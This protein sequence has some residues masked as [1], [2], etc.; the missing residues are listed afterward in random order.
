MDSDKDALPS[1]QLTFEL[2]PL[3]ETNYFLPARN[4]DLSF[5]GVHTALLL[6]QFAKTGRKSKATSSF[7]TVTPE[8]GFKIVKIEAETGQFEGDQKKR[9]AK[10][11]PGASA[12]DTLIALMDMAINSEQEK[13]EFDQ[14][15]ESSQ[16]K[17]LT[18]TSGKSE[19]PIQ[20]TIYFKVKDLAHRIGTQEKNSK[21]VA[22]LQHLSRTRFKIEGTVFHNGSEQKVSHE[23]YYV[24]SITTARRKTSNGNDEAVFSVTLDEKIVKN[25]FENQIAR[26][27]RTKY[28][29][30]PSGPLRKLYILLNSRAHALKNKLVFLTAEEIL[31]VTQIS[32]ATFANKKEQYFKALI[33]AGVVEHYEGIRRNGISIF[34]FKLQDEIEEERN[35]ALHET[36]KYLGIL[37]KL[38]EFDKGF[39]T[40]KEKPSLL[41][42]GEKEIVNL[43]EEYPEV[44]LF[45]RHKYPRVILW[46]DML[47]QS[48]IKYQNI[49]SI[50][51]LLISC[52]KKGQAPTL[53]TGYIPA[54]K[55][56]FSA[57]AERQ[58]LAEKAKREIEAKRLKE[59]LEKNAN[60]AYEALTS[61][62]KKRLSTGLMGQVSS[63]FSFGEQVVRGVCIGALM[64]AMEKGHSPSDIKKVLESYELEKG[65]NPLL[66]QEPER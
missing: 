51:G 52:L 61:E 15:F 40:L 4:N 9:L 36:Q 32:E 43:L 56:Y 64:S 24:S 54:P 11:L 58:V 55:K 45:E 26:A 50:T 5:E 20:N 21:I 3:S 37:E 6:F 47:L 2:D 38:A 62:Q 29:N 33:E 7:R 42:M 46:L 27:N 59:S 10:G 8:G 66:L 35:S 19:Y 23:G 18:T 17:A 30:L 12:Q 28:L 57:L 22:N 49:K 31:G 16:S 39:K 41:D 14:L 1:T 25:I 34:V 13:E 65:P 48:Q 44:E 63:T 60:S 53:S